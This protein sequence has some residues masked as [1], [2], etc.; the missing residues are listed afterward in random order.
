MTKERGILFSGE[1]VNAILAGTKSQTRRVVK[2]QPVGGHSFNSDGSQR[3]RREGQ[4]R[5]PYGAPGD[6]LYVREAWRWSSHE[7]GEPCVCY[8]ADNMCACGRPAQVPADHPYLKWKPGIHLFKTDSRI[9]LRITD[10]RVER[11]QEIANPSERCAPKVQA[12]GIQSCI[13]RGFAT[14][15]EAFADLWDSINAKRGFGW[16]NNPFCWVLTFER[17][18]DA[19]TRPRV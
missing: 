10:V 1:M 12:E 2:P 16:A 3:E 14:F 11:V 18:K 13:E 17:D 9:W 5:C 15:G 8:R 7:A 6:L 4:G 19:E